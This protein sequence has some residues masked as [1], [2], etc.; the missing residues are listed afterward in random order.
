MG[1][2]EKEYSQGKNKLIV[3]V[4]GWRICPLI[5]YDLR[6]PV[7]SRNKNEYDLLVFVANWP[8]TRNDVWNILLK[9][10]AIENQSYVI[11][12]N[13]IGKDGRNI[14][15]SGESQI[16]S[17]KGHTLTYFKDNKE[18]IKTSSLSLSEMREFRNKFPTYLDA[19]DFIITTE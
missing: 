17:P 5:C 18:Y 19:D 16:I 4:N 9:A 12:V 3:N 8:E 2:E 11:G 10:R 7:W 1:G 13:R 14:S 15:Y 6:F